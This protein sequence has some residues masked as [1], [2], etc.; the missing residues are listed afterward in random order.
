MRFVLTPDQKEFFR[1]HHYIEFEG[2]LSSAQAALIEHQAQELVAQRLESRSSKAIAI[3]PL[4][5][6]K[7]GF[8]VWRERPDIKKATQKLS[9]V[10]IASELFDTI[11]LRIAF[12]Q[13]CFSPSF[14]SPFEKHFSLIE[15]SSIKPLAGAILFALQDISDLPKD[16]SFPLPKKAGNALFLSSLF[17]L[18]WPSL[19]SVAHLHFYLVVFAPGKSFYRP[20]PNDPHS[21]FFKK[22][23][24]VFNDPLKESLH[25][26]L[27][28]KK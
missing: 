27:F 23:G 21:P 28:G 7:A 13:Y 15:L 4:T 8:D 10:H 6:Y 20:E 19:F 26:I 18:P 5:L 22:L 12:D 11:P 3:T 16:F 14:Q 25:P 9:T 17:P 2:M 24:Y 1:K